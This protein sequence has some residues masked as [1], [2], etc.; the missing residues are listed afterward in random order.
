[1]EIGIWMEMGLRIRQLCNLSLDMRV[2]RANII[3][4]P[5]HLPTMPSDLIRCDT[6][7]SV[8]ASFL[9]LLFSRGAPSDNVKF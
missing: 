2:R 5:S 9:H 3:G 7:R 4:R 8:P 6:I 1:M